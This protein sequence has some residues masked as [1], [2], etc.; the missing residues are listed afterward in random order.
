MA[1][2]K[3][4]NFEQIFLNFNQQVEQGP[5]GLIPILTFLLVKGQRNG[6]GLSSTYCRFNR[7]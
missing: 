1:S 5:T 6:F 4:C 3:T 2:A 7:W